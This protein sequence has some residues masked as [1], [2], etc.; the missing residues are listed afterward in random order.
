MYFPMQDNQ[1]QNQ[2]RYLH[3]QYHTHTLVLV[4]KIGPVLVQKIFSFVT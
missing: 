1:P 4:Q 3:F 2:I